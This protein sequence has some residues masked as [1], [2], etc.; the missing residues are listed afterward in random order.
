MQVSAAPR[1]PS[2]PFVLLEANLA[3]SCPHK[4]INHSSSVHQIASDPRGQL[5]S[6]AEMCGVWQECPSQQHLT[7]RVSSMK[8]E[9]VWDHCLG[10]LEDSSTAIVHLVP[11]EVY[12]P[13]QLRK[14]GRPFSQTQ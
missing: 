5:L 10:V 13:R 12:G 11:R 2:A 9:L 7:T 1:D 8:H 14:R 4:E 6:I 3:R